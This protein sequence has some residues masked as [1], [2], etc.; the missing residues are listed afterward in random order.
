VVG[1]LHAPLPIT[2]VSTEEKRYE[3]L[4][5]LNNED[6]QAWLYNRCGYGENI[7]SSG[8]WNL[9][10]PLSEIEALMLGKCGKV[11]L[12]ETIDQFLINI[13]VTY[14]GLL[15]RMRLAQVP[16][17]AVSI[18][19]IMLNKII[20]FMIMVEVAFCFFLNICLLG[21]GNSNEVPR[22]SFLRRYLFRRQYLSS[23]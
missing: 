13:G 14:P 2:E 21:R 11:L 16:A 18:S 9:K 23:S 10:K 7:N 15:D 12:D 3:Y 5:N 1:P 8:V 4:L 17:N 6:F 19:S 22:L 20:N